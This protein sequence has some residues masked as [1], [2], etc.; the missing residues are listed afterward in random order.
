MIYNNDDDNNNNNNTTNNKTTRRVEKEAMTLFC[1]VHAG[2]SCVCVPF[3]RFVVPRFFSLPK[4][5]F[6][7]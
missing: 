4:S 5:F 7:W 2:T 6:L 3:S 1:D